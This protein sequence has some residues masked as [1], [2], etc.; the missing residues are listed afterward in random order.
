MILSQLVSDAVLEQAYHWLRKQRRDY[1]ASA[2][3]WSLR[4]AWPVDK[5]RLRRGGG[6][7]VGCTA[8]GL[9]PAGASGTHEE[10]PTVAAADGPIGESARVPLFRALL[11][12]RT[13]RVF[14]LWGAGAFA[15]RPLLYRPLPTV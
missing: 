4:R 13:A 5:I 15:V 8:T 3:V 2:D 14:V 10:P 11:W 6:L 9:R 1:P 12:R 7:E